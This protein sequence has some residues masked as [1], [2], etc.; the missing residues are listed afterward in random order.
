[1]KN[2][3]EHFLKGLKQSIIKNPNE[4]TILLSKYIEKH[5]FGNYAEYMEQHNV[6]QQDINEICFFAVNVGNYN[7]AKDLFENHGATY[8]KLYPYL[9][10]AIVIEHI[11]LLQLLISYPLVN[12]HAP[13]NLDVATSIDLEEIIDIFTDKKQQNIHT[14]IVKH[15][16]RSENL[17]IVKILLD[18]YPEIDID[19]LLMT[20]AKRTNLDMFDYMVAKYSP[21]LHNNNYCAGILR[22]N[23]SDAASCI[24]SMIEK[25]NININHVYSENVSVI[26]HPSILRTI[27]KTPLLNNNLTSTQYSV[28]STILSEACSKNNTH[29]V[30]YLMNKGADISLGNSVAFEKAL[31]YP[32]L[33]RH[34]IVDHGI[35]KTPIIEAILQQNEK[36][37]ILELFAV[38][39]FVDTLQADLPIN[40]IKPTKNKI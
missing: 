7:I 18:A 1:M 29:L 22:K 37:Q 11:P 40:H 16:L 34:L 21:D 24:I 19:K 35:V 10:A 36:K 6:S 2:L 14:D 9:R 38:R 39:E 15:G 27:A 25:Y 26:D 31:K 4:H 3:P 28:Y 8:S 20:A 17:E 33:I 23:R 32:D 12:E 13:R 30:D 5:Q